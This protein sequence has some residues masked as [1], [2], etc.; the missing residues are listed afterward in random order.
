MAAYGHWLLPGSDLSPDVLPLK[1][2]STLLFAILGAGLIWI[3]RQGMV[4]ETHLD[5]VKQEIR[6][7]QRNRRG[8]G[9]LVDTIQFSEVASVVLRRTKAPLVPA[10]LSLR[11]KR[12]S[13]F[14]DL[15]QGQERLL[16][17][18]RDRLFVDM[19]P[20]F[21]APL[22]PRELRQSRAVA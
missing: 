19:S 4:Q 6:L 10:R 2:A 14:V 5:R 7:V 1:M 9:R 22:T 13:G 15:V 17:P 20:K 21:Q 11:L 16:L 3:G 12:S 18:L 8:G